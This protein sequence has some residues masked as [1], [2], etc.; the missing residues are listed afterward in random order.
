MHAAP[1]GKG[2][3]NIP[4]IELSITVV[5]LKA[6]VPDDWLHGFHRFGLDHCVSHIA[7][8]ERGEKQKNLHIQA[9][10]RIH[11]CVEQM[12]AQG[13]PTNFGGFVCSDDITDNVL[14]LAKKEYHRMRPDI[15]A[16]KVKLTPTNLVE[17]AYKFRKYHLSGIPACRMTLMLMLMIQSGEYITDPMS[18]NK[19][20][21][22]FV[23]AQALWDQITGRAAL[24]EGLVFNQLFRI[25]S[26]DAARCQR[27][28]QSDLLA[29]GRDDDALY[30]NK[31]FDWLKSYASG[32]KEEDDND[33]PPVDSRLKEEEE[34]DDDDKDDAPP[35]RGQNAANDVQPF[36]IS[37]PMPECHRRPFTTL[38]DHP[39][40]ERI[41]KDRT[42]RRERRE[43]LE[44]SRPRVATVR[45]DFEVHPPDYAADTAALHWGIDHVHPCTGALPSANLRGTVRR[46][47]VLHAARP[48][49]TPDTALP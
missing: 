2:F 34:E 46:T 36:F 43:A 33:A 13:Q 6:D 7:A 26:R 41:I 4:T 10:A 15:L 47:I 5:A 1:F 35:V 25:Q 22:D 30:A 11:A 49:T 16:G 42:A 38:A 37:D 31:S 24:S 8:L 23:R 9:T 3:T 45:A 40:L 27:N 39:C 19:Q 20:P 28:D 29:V 17:Q 48:S 32:V 18:C 44:A 21:C 12:D 14:N